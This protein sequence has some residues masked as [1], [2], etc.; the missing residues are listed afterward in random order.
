[1]KRITANELGELLKGITKSTICRVEYVVDDSRSKTVKGEKQVQKRV[2]INN[3]YLNHDYTK[4]VQ[5]LTGDTSFVANELKGKTRVCSTLLQSDKSGELLLD[6][7]VLAKE[8]AT[9]L[10]FYHNSRQITAEQGEKLDLWSGAYYKPTEVP[11]MGRGLVS[12]EDDF[13][14]INTTL[15]KIVNIKLEGEEYEICG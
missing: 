5:N 9:I 13:R 6:G 10:A 12:E 15:K 1:M 11:T 2:R 7:K 14:I 3:V 4:K 8:S